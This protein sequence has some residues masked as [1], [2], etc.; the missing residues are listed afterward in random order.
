MLGKTDS[1]PRLHICVVGLNPVP[2]PVPV[3][4]TIR[5][6]GVFVVHLTITLD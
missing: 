3:F 2:V 4:V 5:F 6:K 1:S